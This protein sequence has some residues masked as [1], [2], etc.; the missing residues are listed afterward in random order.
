MYVCSVLITS[1]DGLKG[2]A[3]RACL[4]FLE[5]R[6][7]AAAALRSDR[8]VVTLPIK[9]TVEDTVCV[10]RVQVLKNCIENPENFEN[11]YELDMN[12]CKDLETRT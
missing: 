5:G 9:V 12:M 11:Y 8:H 7:K 10:V 4:E 3:R 1:L 6:V 2:Y